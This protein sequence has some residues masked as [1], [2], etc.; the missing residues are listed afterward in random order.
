MKKIIFI[1]FLILSLLA[2]FIIR[3]STTTPQTPK[4]DYS[5]LNDINS[6]LKDGGFINI[7]CYD[8]KLTLS[9]ISS[10]QLI[11]DLFALVESRKVDLVNCHSILHSVGKHAA[12]KREGY[13]ENLKN[14]KKFIFVNSNCMEGFVHGVMEGFALADERDF[15]S[16]DVKVKE[17]CDS[18]WEDTHGLASE[19]LAFAN[20]PYLACAHG[21]GHIIGTVSEGDY[22]R[23]VLLCDI[24]YSFA[25]RYS[26]ASGLAMEWA[27]SVLNIKAINGVVADSNSPLAVNGRASEICFTKTLSEYQAGACLQY[28]VNFFDRSTIADA[29]I[30]SVCDLTE[31]SM[32]S[33]C[34]LG[35]GMRLGTINT[36]ENPLLRIKGCNLSGNDSFKEI[37]WFTY[38]NVINGYGYKTSVP[39]CEEGLVLLGIK[40]QWVCKNVKKLQKA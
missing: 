39:I 23:G 11:D 4:L 29:E 16:L 15:D 13:I 33:S 24:Y 27:I 14:S 20:D 8:E 25:A 10:E 6:C 7:A 5:A 2:F 21:S 26:C 35:A 38:L 17:V 3:F 31:E 12:N 1:L 22:L 9:K 32:L 37:C 36:K 34:A 28:M 19:M 18:A 30:L 40:S